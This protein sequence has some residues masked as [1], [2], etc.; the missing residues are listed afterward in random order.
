[1]SSYTIELFES[2]DGWRWRI[3]HSNTKILV[4]SE[5]YSSKRKALNT[6]TKLADAFEI[7]LVEK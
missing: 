6:A 3:R 2:K 7:E 1:M 4:S 5:A